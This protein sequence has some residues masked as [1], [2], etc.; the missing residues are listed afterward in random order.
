VGGGAGRQAA[1]SVICDSR[2]SRWPS[3]LSPGLAGVDSRPSLEHP[4]LA[5][6]LD[7]LDVLPPWQRTQPLMEMRERGKGGLVAGAD[8]QLVLRSGPITL[9]RS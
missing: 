7:V 9:A 6:V 3:L 4:E 5:K 1:S 8:G 2:L